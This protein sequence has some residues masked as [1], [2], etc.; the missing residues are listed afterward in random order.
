MWIIE[1]DQLY[2]YSQRGSTSARRIYSSISIV[3]LLFYV[4][5]IQEP[6]KEIEQGDFQGNVFCRQAVL[7][8]MCLVL[9]RRSSQYKYALSP[10]PSSS[11][12]TLNKQATGDRNAL[13]K[14]NL[15]SSSW[16]LS[17]FS[18]PAHLYLLQKHSKKHSGKFIITVEGGRKGQE[19]SLR[20]A[21]EKECSW[22]TLRISITYWNSS[23]QT[24]GNHSPC[25]AP[26]SKKISFSVIITYDIKALNF[27]SLV[28]A[29]TSVEV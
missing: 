1:T 21:M 16:S 2:Q 17:S 3:S 23:S 7:L 19:V 4:Y 29:R 26:H 15:T 14:S 13:K 11:T 9:R 5:Q 22:D 18:T 12:S 28:A 27:Y 10:C 24:L 25:F 8:A 6:T 20:K